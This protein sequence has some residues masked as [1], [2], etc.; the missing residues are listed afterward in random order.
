MARIPDLVVLFYEANKKRHQDFIA[1]MEHI[2]DDA[3]RLDIVM[4]KAEGRRLALDLGLT[5]LPAVVYYENGVPN[6]FAGDLTREDVQ[7]WFHEH[8]T[9]GHAV[10]VTGIMLE[11]LV[12]VIVTTYYTI[13]T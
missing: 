7:H 11:S 3:E 13:I 10:R 1:Q 4:V 9:G 2:D 5:I 12:L 6:V 8:R